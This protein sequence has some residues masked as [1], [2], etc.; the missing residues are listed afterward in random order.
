MD[1]AAF[2]STVDSVAR[3]IIATEHRAA[4]SF[5]RTP[6][7]YPSGSTVVVQI[8]EAAGRYFVTDM[9]FGYQEAEM[10][11]AS[12]IYSRHAGA[13]ADSA[14]ISFDSQAFFIAEA[15]REQLAGAAV[16]V[17]NCSQEATALAAFKLAERKAADDAERLY[18]RLVSVFSARDVVKDAEVYGASNTKWP[19]AALVKA[20]GDRRPTVFEPVRRHHSSVAHASMKFHDLAL[21]ERPPNRIAV[22]HEKRDFGTLLGVLTQAASVIDD[23]VSDEALLRLAKVA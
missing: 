4:G 18:D 1:N 12:F 3:E 22:V 7:L 15:P 6:L 21:L 13:V 2:R 9:G 10:M 19:V 14:G 20:N 23:T 11:G 17:A 8:K 16:T 5:I